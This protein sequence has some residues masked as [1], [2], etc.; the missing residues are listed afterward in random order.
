MATLTNDGVESSSANGAAAGVTR[1][2]TSKA[3][4]TYSH[5]NPP[6]VKRRWNVSSVTYL[7][8]YDGRN[9][10]RVNFTNAFPDNDYVATEGGGSTGTNGTTHA[11]SISNRLTTSC[12]I[13]CTFMSGNDAF[14][15][16]NVS[17]NFN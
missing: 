3:H 4:V 7:S 15:R 10:T 17:L 8:D 9:G 5:A 11:T 13:C 12:T 6:E 16:G 2:V 14:P 1:V